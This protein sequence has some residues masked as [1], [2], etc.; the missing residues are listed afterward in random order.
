MSLVGPLVV[1]Q[2]QRGIVVPA[3]GAAG[4]GVK[5]QGVSGNGGT[6]VPLVPAHYASTIAGG[7]VNSVVVVSAPTVVA[8][9]GPISSTASAVTSS[10][11]VQSAKH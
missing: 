6:N 7:L 8:Q 11:A 3:G 2:S 5:T 10:G 9:S 1:S 4:K